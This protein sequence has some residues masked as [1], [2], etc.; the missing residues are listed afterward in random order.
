[1]EAFARVAD[2]AAWLGRGALTPPEAAPGISDPIP[3][4]APVVS[5]AARR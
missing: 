5:A 1:M 3:V 2:S 4:A